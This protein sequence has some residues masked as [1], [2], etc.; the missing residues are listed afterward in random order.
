MTKIKFIKIISS[1]IFT[2]ISLNSNASCPEVTQL[3]YANDNS[4]YAQSNKGTWRQ[5]INTETVNSNQIQLDRLFV[6]Y[7][8]GN[9]YNSIIN[10]SANIHN[11][12]CGYKDL[13]KNYIILKS[14]E[15]QRYRI[16]MHQDHSTQDFWK[17]SKENEFVC[18]KDVRRSNYQ[19]LSNQCEFMAN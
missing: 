12:Y 9:G 8:L 16:S 14:P 1:C 3:R 13:N 5:L 10:Y 19:T 18:L 17:Q 11:I 6:F 7:I 15:N 2:I 4:I